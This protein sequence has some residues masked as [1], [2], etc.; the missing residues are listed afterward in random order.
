MSPNWQQLY[1][2][3][4]QDFWAEVDARTALAREWGF[5]QSPEEFE[6][7]PEGELLAEWELTHQMGI[8]RPQTWR[9]TF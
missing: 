1:E 4:C 9:L 5:E 2:T 7:S 3:S 8:A 6:K